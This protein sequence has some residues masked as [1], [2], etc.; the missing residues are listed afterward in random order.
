[1]KLVQTTLEQLKC[2]SR[3]VLSRNL[4]GRTCCSPW[5]RQIGVGQREEWKPNFITLSQ[6]VESYKVKWGMKGH[7]RHGTHYPHTPGAHHTGLIAADRAALKWCRGPFT[8]RSPY[9]KI[10][11]YVP[12]IWHVSLYVLH[13]FDAH[14]INVSY[15]YDVFWTAMQWFSK[16][17]LE[18]SYTQL[19]HTDLVQMLSTYWAAVDQLLLG[20]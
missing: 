11:M 12:T 19:D 4:T 16:S 8:L 7:W 20:P 14:S 1:M 6:H 17:C 2:T 13:W 15:C 3:D 5:L 18:W 10:C 9:Q